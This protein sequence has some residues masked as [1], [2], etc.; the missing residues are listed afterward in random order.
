MYCFRPNN[1]VPDEKD[2]LTF[3]QNVR[4]SLIN[5]RT[6]IIN[7]AL[8]WSIHTSSYLLFWKLW[9]EKYTWLRLVWH[10]MEEGCGQDVLMLLFKIWKSLNSRYFRSRGSVPN[11]TAAT[12]VLLSV[13]VVVVGRKRWTVPKLLCRAVL[14]D[15]TI[16]MNASQPHAWSIFVGISVSA[17]RNKIMWIGTVTSLTSF[18][19]GKKTVFPSISTNVNNPAS[20]N[21]G[22]LSSSRQTGSD[23]QFSRW[24][25]ESDP[26][27]LQ[28]ATGN[29]EVRPTATGFTRP[30]SPEWLR[31][32]VTSGGR[33]QVWCG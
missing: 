30:G 25:G 1:G 10:W 11:T 7:A 31:S 27:P 32:T 19:F 24:R 23:P 33:S 3:G 22:I 28:R 8:H 26:T 18:H 20:S 5:T 15:W 13:Y 4:R 17:L 2:P 9:T 12:A 29:R 21:N 6:L 14:L 16:F